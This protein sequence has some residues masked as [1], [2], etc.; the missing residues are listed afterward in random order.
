[1]IRIEIPGRDVIGIEHLVL[2]Y[3]GTI[4]EDGELIEGV[5]DRLLQ[6]KEDV[7]VHVLTAD[8][9]GTVRQQCEPLGINV[10]TFPRAGA[11]E[12]KLKI[13]QALGRHCMCIGNGYN[14]VLM[15]GEAELSVAVIEHECAFSEAVTSADVVARSIEDALDLLLKPNRLRATLRS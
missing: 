13:V 4:A 14:D 6:L 11:A 5:A 12:C 15:F 8:T 9:Y 10:E 7:S 2:D 1:M 3:N